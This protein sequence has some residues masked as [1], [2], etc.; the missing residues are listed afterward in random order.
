[1]KTDL[2]RFLMSAIIIMVSLVIVDV[3]VGM[4]GGKSLD[5]LPDFT[6]KM[7]AQTVKNN[8]RIMRMEQDIVIVGSS[9][10]SHH[11]N[12]TLLE[13]SIKT[14]V[15]GDFSIYNAGIDGQ[16]SNSSCMVIESM[17][18]RYS[19]KMVILDIGDTNLEFEKGKEMKLGYLNFN[20]PYYNKIETAK[21]YFDDLGWKERLLVKSG[22]YSYNDKVFRIGQGFLKMGMGTEP[23]D[24]FEPLFGT[25][26]DTTKVE[27]KVKKKQSQKEMI[28]DEYSE[29]N[30]CRV[31]QLCK[32]KNVNLVL[33]SSPRFRPKSDNKLIRSLSQEYD[34]PYIEIYN[35]DFFNAHPE[36]FKDSSHLN[37]DGATLYT[38]MFFEALKPYLETLKQ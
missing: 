4:I 10:A 37:N 32:E 29:N 3:A 7:S 30:L 20:A 21:H 31:M 38:Q 19:P 13:D 28:V 27:T 26:I 6:S 1:M 33:V 15:D 18:D 14:C 23:N 8:Y 11:Y 2:S 35:T 5:Y 22:L 24:G 9:R 34:I 36:L 16:F 12:T 25:S 17:L